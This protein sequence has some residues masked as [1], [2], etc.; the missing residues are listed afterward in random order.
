MLAVV[1]EFFKHAVAAKA[2]DASVLGALY[3]VGDDRFLP[4]ELRAEGGGLRYRARPRHQLRA[5]RAAS[6]EAASQAEWE[7]LL[8]AATSWRERFLLVLL[9][10]CGLRIGETLGLRRA[11]LHFTGSSTS[12][13]CRVPGPHLHV[14]HRDG[15]PNGASAKSRSERT[16]PVVAWVLAYYDRYTAER[17]ACPAAD[18]CDFVFVNLFHAPLGAPMTASAVRQVMRVLSRRAGLAR[19]VHP[20]MLRH[21]SGSEMADAGV[22]I[23]RRPGASGPRVDHLR[24][25]LCAPEPGSDA[26]RRRGGRESHLAASRTTPGR[27]S[28]V[29]GGRAERAGRPSEALVPEEELRSVIDWAALGRLGFAPGVALFAPGAEDPVFGFA[30]CRAASCD[31]VVHSGSLGLCW[32]CGQLW[33]KAGQGADFEVFCATVPGRTRHNRGGALCRVC[34]TPGHERPVR[35][36]GLCTMC[37]KAM[38]NRGQSPDEYVNGD[39]EYE[40]AVPRPAFGRCLVTVCDR[41]A[42]RRPGFVRGT[43]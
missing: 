28:P 10:F 17:L 42:W 12:L 38:A 7:A 2:V 25:A 6:P 30:V 9:W 3:E 15:N 34:R 16:V 26:Q 22:P 35:S 40:A 31:Q 37:S 18:G 43:R 23:E 14:V 13:G 20:H 24:A 11:D 41:W 5:G 29:N 39:A 21:S 33:Q 19:P 8:E 4:A 32:R 36:H 1:R 27:R